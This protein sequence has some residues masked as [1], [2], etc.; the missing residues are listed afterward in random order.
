MPADQ[1]EEKVAALQQL[2]GI[3]TQAASLGSP[4]WAVA[5]LWSWRLAYKHLADVVDATPAPG[6]ASAAEV[7]SSA[8]GEGAGGAAEGSARTTPSRRAWRAPISSTCSA[9]RWWAAAR[10]A[11]RPRCRCPRPARPRGAGLVEEL[12]KKAEATLDAPSAR[13][14]GHGVP[15]AQAATA[16]RSSPSAAST[17]IEDT[18]ASAHNALGWALLSRATPMGARAAYAQGARGGP[19]L[20]EGA[21][22][23]GRAALPL[24]RR[25]GRQARAVA[26]SR[27]P[28]ALERPRR[29]P[30]VEDLPV[31]AA[32]HCRAPWLASR[33]AGA[34]LRAQGRTS[35]AACAAD[36]PALRQRSEAVARPSGTRLVRALRHPQGTGENTILQGDA[37]RAGQ[38]CPTGGPDTEIDLAE[39]TGRSWT[40]RSAAGRRSVLDDPRAS[41]P[42]L[43]GG[44]D[45]RQAPCRA[46]T[47][48]CAGDFHVT[49]VNGID[50]YSGRTIFGRFEAT[51]P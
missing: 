44:L 11:T 27:T 31:S 7:R 24:R 25:R 14:A 5:S 15:G 35:R 39:L 4:E 51:V 42:Q 32:R 49:F 20:R 26:C 33:A 37:L 16:W 34:A 45:L 3:Y 43:R 36:G 50:V 29:R 2:E 6:G 1:V 17:E 12:R 40:R 10:R 18:R 47:S 23:P 8:G 9:P 38:A 48:Q 28:S 19:H 41:S 13:G 22:E 30:G 21:R 46:A